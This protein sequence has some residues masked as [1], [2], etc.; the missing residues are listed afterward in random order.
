MVTVYKNI[1][2]K[3]K[4]LRNR[5]RDSCEKSATGEENTGILRIPAGIT[6]LGALLEPSL[7]KAAA[8]YSVDNQEVLAAENSMQGWLSL[9]WYL[10]E[11]EE[12]GDN[13]APNPALMEF[14]ARAR[15]SAFTTPLHDHTKRARDDD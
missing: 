10:I 4:I 12:R 8:E 7:P 1:S 6:N 5:N 2:Q 11:A 9:F 3:K 15:T 14:A 13:R